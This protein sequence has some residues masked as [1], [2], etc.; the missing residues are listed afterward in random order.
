MTDEEIEQAI[1]EVAYESIEW[2]KAGS[3]GALS[4]PEKVCQPSMVAPESK[5]SSQRMQGVH[6]DPRQLR[7]LVNL[8]KRG[9]TITTLSFPRHKFMRPGRT[10]EEADEEARRHAVAFRQSLIQKWGIRQ[11]GTSGMKYINWQRRVFWQ[12]IWYEDGKCKKRAFSASKYEKLGMSSEE[13]RETA[14]WN[15]VAFR[16]SVMRQ[17]PG[18]RQKTETQPKSEVRSPT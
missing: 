10:E 3:D 1:N 5:C 14:M 4:T 13:A 16:A 8:Q 6:W 17:R 15:A 12:A 2:E 18:K 7:W 11:Y 9:E